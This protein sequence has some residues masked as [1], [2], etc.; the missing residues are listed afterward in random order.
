MLGTA[1]VFLLGVV[2]GALVLKIAF[3]RAPTD[4]IS[5]VRPEDEQ[6]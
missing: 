5:P 2:V 4:V 6:L 3:Y 1:E